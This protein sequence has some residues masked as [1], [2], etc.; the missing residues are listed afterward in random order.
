MEK[1]TFSDTFGKTFEAVDWLAK[2]KNISI[3]ISSG[4]V[5]REFISN[6]SQD[7]NVMKFVPKHE[8]NLSNEFSLQCNFDADAYL[9]C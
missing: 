5:T 3:M 9:D 2:D 8:K 4:L 6:Y 1:K 7:I